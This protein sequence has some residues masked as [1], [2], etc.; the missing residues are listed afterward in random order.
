MRAMTIKAAL[1]AAVL[2]SSAFA[3][4]DVEVTENQLSVTC[5]T[6]GTVLAKVVAPDDTVVADRQFEGYRFTW[7]PSGADGRTAPTAT[8]SGWSCP[9]PKH[10]ELKTARRPQRF[11][12]MPAARWKSETGR[13]SSRP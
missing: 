1:L 11:R 4:M 7:H 6:S 5:D 2:S 3:A 12:S 13:S 8:T 9:R 10:R